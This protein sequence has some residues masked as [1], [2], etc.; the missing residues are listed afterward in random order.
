M[1]RATSVKEKITF[2]DADSGCACRPGSIVCA[3]LRCGGKGETAIG[4]ADDAK[5]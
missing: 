2:W 3:Y 5:G 1:G 4:R